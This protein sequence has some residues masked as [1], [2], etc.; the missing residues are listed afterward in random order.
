MGRTAGRATARHLVF[1]AVCFAVFP[2]PAFAYLDPGTGSMILQLV[3][4]GVAGALVVI[5]LYWARF[6]AFVSGGK[7]DTMTAAEP[8]G[9]AESS[10]TGR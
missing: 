4:G 6:K 2:L 10:D 7:G 1:F 3:I 8:D 5:K 9:D